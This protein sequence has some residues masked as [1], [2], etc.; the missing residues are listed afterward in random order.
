MIWIYPYHFTPRLSGDR[1]QLIVERVI[2]NAKRLNADETRFF[3]ID[4][5][6]SNAGSFLEQ[7]GSLRQ[8]VDI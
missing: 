8:N 7:R 4:S 6:G 3:V 2:Q 5:I 1:A